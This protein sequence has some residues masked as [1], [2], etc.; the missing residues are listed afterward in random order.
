M[1]LASAVVLSAIILMAVGYV[2][3]LVAVVRS[4]SG[5]DV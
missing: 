2:V 1:W 5:H 4:Q 3:L